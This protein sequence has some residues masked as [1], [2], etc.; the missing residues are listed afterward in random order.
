[1]RGP[2][3]ENAGSQRVS[4]VRA[5]RDLQ[6]SAA[7]EKDFSEEMIAPCA[8]H[9]KLLNPDDVDLDLDDDED[10]ATQKGRPR[11]NFDSSN[12]KAYLRAR[13]DLGPREKYNYPKVSSW[14]YGW[15]QAQQ[16]A[17]KNQQDCP[18]GSET[19]SPNNKG[20]F[21]GRVCHINKT[22]FRRNGIF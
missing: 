19:K 9:Q 12:R 22:F 10:H 13:T 16:P 2:A 4:F 15:S 18:S 8:S 14:E 6:D 5:D 11:D 17:V 7:T 20:E 1:M 3:S 21:H